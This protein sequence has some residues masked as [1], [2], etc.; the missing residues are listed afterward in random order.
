[1]LFIEKIMASFASL[2]AID[3]MNLDSEDVAR[4]RR[5]HL[6]QKDVVNGPPSAKD[7]RQVIVRFGR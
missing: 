6:G 4:A 1:M 3:L 7:D 5:A 2:I